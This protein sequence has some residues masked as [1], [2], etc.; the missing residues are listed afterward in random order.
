MRVDLL[1]GKPV[2]ADE[3]VL[4]RLRRADARRCRGVVEDEITAA[5]HRRLHR[6]V[7]AGHRGINIAIDVR[8]REGPK[9]RRDVARG[10]L[11]PPLH[12]EQVVDA[13]F[14]DEPAE[15]SEV[16]VFEVSR[17]VRIHCLVGLRHPFEGIE[18]QD[19][20]TWQE[21]CREVRHEDRVTALVRAV[22][23][24]I[25]ARDARKVELDK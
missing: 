19:L 25:A 5:R 23:N 8:E 22:L 17:V 1:A 20:H 2:A 13:T 3:E 16:C 15:T 7:R 4:H 21:P 11:E 18:G 9:L 6:L 10:V 12:Q 24:N 14:G